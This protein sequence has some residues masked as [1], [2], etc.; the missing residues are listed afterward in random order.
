MHFRYETLHLISKFW[1]IGC[2]TD[3][4]AL[5]QH[6]YIHHTTDTTQARLEDT[7]DA[8]PQAQDC[9]VRASSKQER[10]DLLPGSL[11]AINL[12][13]HGAGIAFPGQVGLF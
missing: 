7:A 11:P 9:Q 6:F 2:E 8:K 5:L 3:A 10:E 13:V 12:K 4:N 1:Q